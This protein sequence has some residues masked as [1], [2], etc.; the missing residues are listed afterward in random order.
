MK[1]P[2]VSVCIPTYQA[3]ATLGETLESLLRQTHKSLDVVVCDN[4]S[5]D[6]TLALAGRFRDPRL[7]IVGHDRTVSAEG[8]FERCLALARGEFTCLFHA[9]DVYEPDIVEREVAFLQAHPR[10]GAVFTQCRFVDESGRGHALSL[11]PRGLRGDLDGV[12]FDFQTAFRLVLKYGN[13]VVCP[14][15][16]A[17]TSIYQ[18]EV[19]TWADPRYGS[20]ADLDV[21]FRILQR[22]TMGC[23]PRPLMRYRRAS[24]SFSVLYN[25]LRTTDADYLRVLDEYVQRPELRTWLTASDHHAYAGLRRRHDVV[26]ANN[27]LLCGDRDLARRLAFSST[28]RE[29]FAAALHGGRDLRVLVVLMA[30]RFGLHAPRIVRPILRYIARRGG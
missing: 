6:G 10:A 11:L 3:E 24:T 8:N 22:N 19:R 27:A 26:R 14:S 20:S 15:V 9:D 13:F 29:A 17:R 28:S 5:T 30:V 18:K 12:E 2:L 23:L 4:A 7:R 25:R 1:G 16:M 21:W